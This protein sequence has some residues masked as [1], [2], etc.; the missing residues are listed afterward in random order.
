MRT[1][2][3]FWE[4]ING[5]TVMVTG[6]SSGLGEAFARALA[7]RVRKLILV[8][9]R[10]DRLVELRAELMAAHGTLEEVRVCRVDLSDVHERERLV[11]EEAGSVDVLV[12][13]AGLGDYGDF[14]G[15]EW[16]RTSAMLEVNI[17]AVTR[18]AHGVLPGM[19][20][21]GAGVILNVSSLAGEIFI[22]DFAVYAAS[23]AYVTR[24][25]E[26]LR[27]EVRGDGV[28]VVAVCP[29]PVRT[30]FGAVAR[31]G[32]HGRSERPLYR[33]LYATPEEVVAAAL[34]AVEAGRAQVFPTWRVA[35][36]AAGLQW[37][38]AW[39][40][41]LALSRRPRRVEGND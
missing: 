23:K 36:L 11:E 21:R 38:P 40:R 24:F 34:A 25:S 31:R 7:P 8:A 4:M 37:L 35:W 30:E 19:R 15:S 18:L 3:A 26:A 6:A 5:S 32:G 17:A 28:R 14:S 13:N 20:A 22:P 1:Y 2:G 12:N 16:T 10:E 41:R 9:R 39:G 33:L 27:I 29:G